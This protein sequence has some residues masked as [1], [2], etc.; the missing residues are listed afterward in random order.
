MK[1]LIYI[2][3][4]KYF[5]YCLI[6]PIKMFY[7]LKTIIFSFLSLINNEDNTPKKNIITQQNNTLSIDK[8]VDSLYQSLTLRQKIGQLFMVRAYSDQ[9][10]EKNKEILSWIKKYN[11]GGICFFQGSPTRQVKLNN[12]FQ[13]NTK[14]PLFIAI[15]G[16][17]GLGMRLDSTLSYPRAMTLGAIR[18]DTL[19]R[20]MGRQIAEQCK[21][22]GI[23]I[24]FAPVADVNNNAENPVIADRS[25]GETTAL[26]NQ[27][28]L[29]YMEGMQEK[30]LIA[31]AKHFPGHGDT[32]TDSHEL[33]PVIKK[34]NETLENLELKPFQNLIDN[35]IKA[36]M[37]AHLKI[38]AWDTLPTSLSKKVITGILQDKLNFQGLV[39]TDALEMKGIAGYLPNGALEL[40][41][42]QAGVDVLLI[43]ADVPKAVVYLENAYKKGVFTEELLAKKVKKILKAKLE[44]QLFTKKII[45]KFDT[46]QLH[47]PEYYAL[48]QKLFKSSITLVKNQ[49]NFLPLQMPYP[50]PIAS[51][52]FN[53]NQKTNWQK[54]MELYGNITHF[55]I[56]QK[57][58]LQQLDSFFVAIKK[59]PL[60]I[61]GINGMNR[62]RKENYNLSS[63]QKDFIEKLSKISNTCISFFGS[64]YS[65]SLNKN[66]TDK[67][68]ICAYED[69]IYT[70]RAMIQSIFGAEKIE[71]KLPI[72]VNQF[73]E[74]TGLTLLQK[75][76]YIA[77]QH[78]STSMISPDSL[79]K[80]DIM[81]NKALKQKLFSGG[82]IT[83]IHQNKIIFEKNYGKTA[84]KNKF[85]PQNTTENHLFDVASLTKVLA[86]LP[87]VMYLY[88]KGKIDIEQKASFYI[89]DLKN[90]NKENITIKELLT[91]QSGLEPYQPHYIKTLLNKKPNPKWYQN[92]KSNDFSIAVAENLFAKNGLKDSLWTWTLN[93]KRTPREKNGL[94]KYEYS[95]INF[96]LLKK[97]CDKLLE[98]PSEIFVDEYLYQPLGLQKTTF[99]PL[100]KFNK[101][102]IALT[103]TD[104]YFRMQTIQGYVHDPGAAMHGG[105]AG[106]AGL[107]S[108]ATEVAILM[109][110]FLQNGKYGNKVFFQP[111]T[112]Q[113]FIKPHFE[114]NRRG[115][116]WDRI[117]KVNIGYIPNRASELSFGHSGFTGC[118][119]WADMKKELV[120]V[121]LSNRVHPQVRKDDKFVKEHFRRKLMNLI[122]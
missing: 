102:S 57:A 37:I 23:H 93:C 90:T 53:T 94:N 87:A 48:I 34:T 22:M 113:T 59:F 7:F 114:G 81:V 24:N 32:D 45:E 106:H 36:V 78:S 79:A 112:I 76:N 11:I 49:D 20:E 109:D 75:E 103:E 18:N 89:D 115:L 31:T 51:L 85:N 47:K 107:F 4:Q 82:Q 77:S 119:A 19:I 25:F 60:V 38:P 97:I 42:L 83:I 122:F 1:Y 55:N 72:S 26:V 70:Q 9:K 110:V 56:P 65:L 64:P 71:G 27:K 13:K 108:T 44:A 121:F 16:E 43:A 101:N 69:N 80:I 5:Y 116:G 46:K 8:K 62:R 52:S 61:V 15:D 39:F 2:C 66:S 86:T 29:A 73:L 88:E 3:I 99:N 68:I 100:Q 104:N 10:N 54:E 120:F 28:S 40:Q 96:Y 92:K 74:G 84:F 17:W 30:G 63:I 91:H 98:K 14:T 35:K 67:S 6:L 105:V 118:V 50:Y 12:L 117:D 33:L 95:D 21:I 111:S 41:A 58:N